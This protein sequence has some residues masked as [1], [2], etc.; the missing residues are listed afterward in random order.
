M[1]PR[2]F[3]ALALKL[4][5]L[6]S[7]ADHRT[8]VGRSYYSLFNL[9]RDQL[10]ARGVKFGRDTSDHKRLPSYL[11]RSNVRDAGAIATALQNLRKSRTDCDYEMALV[12]DQR[13]AQIAVGQ[14]QSAIAR[15]DEMVKTKA[16]DIRLV[17]VL[18]SL[19]PDPPL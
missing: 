16:L 18:K 11:Q 9:L 6:S 17:P 7:E 15:F 14:A 4:R 12:V 2:D 10:A 1:D 5:D 19:P 3:F 8:S 13:S